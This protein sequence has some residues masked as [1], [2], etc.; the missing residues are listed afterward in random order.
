MRHYLQ[1]LFAPQSVALVGA[2]E[3][4]AS[5]GRIVYEN[6]LGGGF[7]GDIYAVNP[8][9]SRILAQPAF[10]SLDAIGRTVDLAI[11]A[12]P[13]EAVADILANV[14][15]V[16]RAAILMSAPTRYNRQDAAAW[17]R[18]LASI[19]GKRKIKLIGPGALGVIRTDIGLNA[20][21]CAPVAHRGRLA[22]LA[23]SGA[24]SAAMLD[25]A[26]PMGI[27]F[28]SVLSFSAGIGVGFRRI[29]RLSAARRCDRRNPALY[30][31]HGR[32]TR[33]HVCVAIR[34]LAQNRWWR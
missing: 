27:G 4:P 9:H 8:K 26:A 21:Y 14:T 30:R 33:V 12:S 25:F 31:R 3:R 5:L 2:S 18:R 15:K 32:R 24:V 10:A 13:P 1:P 16:P 19:A 7:S 23:Q 20:T 22:L 17:T 29:A 11:V 6:L 34:R 28:S